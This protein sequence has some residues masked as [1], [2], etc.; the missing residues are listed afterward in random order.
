VTSTAEPLIDPFTDLPIEQPVPEPAAEA[1]EPVS[2]W[3]ERVLPPPAHPAVADLQAALDRVAALQRSG[4]LAVGVLADAAALQRIAES[5][6]GVAL[7][8]LAAVDRRKT[9]A[10]V[11]RASAAGWLGETLVLHDV[12]ARSRVNLARRLTEDLAPIGDLL[13][14]GRTT[15]EHCKALVRGL[16]GLTPEFV[17]A[18]IEPLGTLVTGMDPPSVARELRE[19]AHAVSDE[20]AKE[21]AK[22]QRQRMGI[23]CDELLD[24]CVSVHG[25]LAP[26]EG[27]AL[28]VALD[29]LVHGRR[30]AGDLRD[31]PARRA[32][33]LVSLAQHALECEGF[34]PGRGGSRAQ[35]IVLVQ[36]ETLAGEPGAAPATFPGAHALLTRQQLLRMTCDADI[37]TVLLDTRADGSKVVLDEGRTKRTITA[38]QWKALVGRDQH[39]VVKGCRR[40]PGQSQAHHVQHWALDGL[41]DLDNYCLVCHLHHHQLHEGAMRLQHRDGRWLTPDGYA[42]P[43]P[44]PPLF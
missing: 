8:E 29:A 13:V 19:R 5:A 17:A 38:A 21:Q 16:R 30:E 32:E 4:E 33:A 31:A 20:I 6:A 3:R 15:V 28:L 40:R 7:V 27:Q 42:Q 26:E 25:L 10:E 43:P 24:G 11:G 23:T 41:S 37:S 12:A 1:A 9:F 39:C 35:V 22:R 18:M 34:L 14:Q 36:A 44:G 2:P